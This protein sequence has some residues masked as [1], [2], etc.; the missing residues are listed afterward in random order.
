MSLRDG[1]LVLDKWKGVSSNQALQD[2]RRLFS[3][4]RVE[5]KK[6]KVGH[7]GTLDPLAT[8]MLILCFG[9]ATKFSQ[10]LLNADKTYQVEAELGTQTTTGDAEGT[11][12]AQAS[13][14]LPYFL[15]PELLEFLACFK[16]PITQV[17]SMYS[18]LKHQG[19]PLYEWAREGVEV[20][21]SPRQVMIHALDL[22]AYSGETL[23]LQIS[24]SKG[25]YIRTLIEDLGHSMGMGAHVKE[26]RRISV[27]DFLPHEMHTLESL[28]AMTFEERYS[29]L[30]PLS[31]MVENWNT[32]VL[33]ELAIFY[34]KRGQPVQIPHAPLEGLVQLRQRDQ[35]FLGVGK[36]LEDGRIAPMCLVQ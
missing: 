4:D 11:V 14:P 10:F 6:L 32:V 1:I 23:S 28:E 36:I 33:N 26:L 34:L 24:C 25:T 35:Q 3:R 22:T 16:G 30:L 7:T 18:A 12:V 31:R 20:P 8:G 21:R 9:R 27:G 13:R 15:E 17:P 2:I 5:F 29:A 19:K